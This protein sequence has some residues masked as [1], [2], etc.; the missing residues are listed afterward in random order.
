[1]R[2]PKAEAVVAGKQPSDELLKEAADVAVTECK[3]IDDFRASANY[4]H[5]LVRTMTYRCLKQSVEIAS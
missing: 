5:Q 3:P 4:R 2:C 1:M